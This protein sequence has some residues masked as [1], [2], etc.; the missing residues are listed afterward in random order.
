MTPFGSVGSVV[1]VRGHI[2]PDLQSSEPF[3]LFF[4][5]HLKLVQ[6]DP[7]KS[8]RFFFCKYHLVVIFSITQHGLSY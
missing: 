7:K 4:V 3:L 5:S 1:G 2:F 6:Y 8:D